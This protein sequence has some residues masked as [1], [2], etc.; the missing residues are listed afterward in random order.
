M[1]Y[2]TDEMEKRF[3]IRRDIFCDARATSWQSAA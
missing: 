3:C 1:I 2:T